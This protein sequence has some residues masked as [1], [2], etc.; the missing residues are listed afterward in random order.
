VCGDPAYLP[1]QK[2][3]AVQTL[4]PNDPP[5]CLHAWRIGFVHPLETRRLE[6]RAPPPNWAELGQ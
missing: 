3:G 4:S 1:G 2:L 5:L 6:F